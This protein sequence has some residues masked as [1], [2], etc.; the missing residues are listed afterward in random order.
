MIKQPKNLLFLFGWLGY[1]QFSVRFFF[2]NLFLF[3]SKIEQFVASLMLLHIYNIITYV[4]Y[5]VILH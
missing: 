5:T 3:S 2:P 4:I 1:L